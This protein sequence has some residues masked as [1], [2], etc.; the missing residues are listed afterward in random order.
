MAA[1]RAAGEA[2]LG[3]L[4]EQISPSAVGR[5]KAALETLI[6]T[7]RSAAA[8]ISISNFMAQVS[9]APLLPVPIVAPKS[10]RAEAVGSDRSLHKFTPV[11][12]TAMARQ[13]RLRCKAL[14]F[15]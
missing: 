7:I 9:L 3:A 1:Q 14:M 13:F 5:A 10:G 11:P 6:Q 8:A 2:S 4:K 15:E 12:P